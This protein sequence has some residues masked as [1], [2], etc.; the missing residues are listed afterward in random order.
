[1]TGQW[2]G[3]QPRDG[4]QDPV[5]FW[6]SGADGSSPKR[7]LAESLTRAAQPGLRLVSPASGGGSDQPE[8][9]GSGPGVTVRVFLQVWRTMFGVAKKR[10]L[11]R[12]VEVVELGLIARARR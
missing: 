11:R 10:M 2:A 12:A 8:S 7:E 9:P 4:V 1:M 6:K 5:F 3:L